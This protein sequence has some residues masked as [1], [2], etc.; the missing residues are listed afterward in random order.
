MIRIRKGLDLPIAGKPKQTIEAG[1]DVRH[2][3][4]VAGDYVGMK[5]TMEVSVGDIVKK[6]QLLFSDKKTPGVLYTAP[7]AGKVTE[8]NRGAKRAFLSMVI[9]KDGEDEV[10]FP[11]FEDTDLSNL[12]PKEVK[13]NLLTS[14]MWP[15]LRTRPYS[16][17]PAVDTQPKSIFVTA[18]DTNPLAADPEV[19]IAESRE[20]FISGLKILGV[21]SADK[22]YVCKSPG[23]E[24]PGSD[25]SFVQEEEFD[26]PHP[27]GLPGTHIH[28]LDPVGPRKTVWHV[29]YQDVIAIGKLFLTGSLPTERVVAIGGPKAK[30]PRLIRTQ[31]GASL[32]EL[33]KD[34][35]DTAEAAVRVISGSVF[36]GRKSAGVTAYLGRYHTQISVLEEGT[37]R[38]FL[39]WQA[40]GFGKYSVK[41]IFASSWFG[42]AKDLPMTTGTGGSKRAMVPVGSYEQVM[43]LD[44]VPTFLMRALITH[45]TAL[46]QDLGA[47]E[48]DEEDVA[49]CTFVCPGKYEYGSLLR[50]NLTV[51][52]REG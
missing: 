18:M 48:M 9:E 34:E 30:N 11:S 7:A 10:K 35:I 1:A 40:P 19:I 17:V 31:V 24:I 6:G 23:A 44:T 15:V 32:D 43:P 49:L 20:H 47:L 8:V 2:V 50:Q 5:P 22:V 16:K 3:A 36:S 21:L 28:F 27:A 33:M 29:G 46:A 41:N 51:I 38:E 13:E 26:G 14:G 45:D 4:L 39:G 12:K 25:L 42:G 52:E 37:K